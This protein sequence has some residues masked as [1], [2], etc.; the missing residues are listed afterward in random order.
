MP[1]SLDTLDRLKFTYDYTIK[2]F[3]NLKREMDNT[4]KEIWNM[5]RYA[6]LATGAIWTWG[7]P[8]SQTLLYSGLVKWLPLILNGL[9]IIRVFS[10]YRHVARISDYILMQ[11]NSLF[12]KEL[13]WE[14]SFRKNAT[15]FT[16]ATGFI[17][18]GIL[19]AGSLLVPLLLL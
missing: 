13:R 5:E 8:N 6:L 1:E 15:Q 2:E 7:I 18:W 19:M 10:M 3:E 12:Q 16:A 17:F 11:E 9:F 4:I 14:R